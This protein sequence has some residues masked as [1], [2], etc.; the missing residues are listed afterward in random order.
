MSGPT[1]AVEQ[2][3]RQLIAQRVIAICL[4]YEDLNDHDRLRY[5]P[6]VAA[7]CGAEDPTGEHRRRDRDKG[8]ALA[9]KNTMDRLESGGREAERYTNNGTTW[10]PVDSGLTMTRVWSLAVSGTNLFAGTYGGGVFLSANNGT[11]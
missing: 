1:R 2:G 11:S 10:T 3:L 6:L 8:K 5:D 4:G 9:E 7:V